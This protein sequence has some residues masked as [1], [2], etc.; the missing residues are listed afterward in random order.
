MRSAIVEQRISAQQICA[1]LQSH[2]MRRAESGPFAGIK[3]KRPSAWLEPAPGAGGAARM[4]LPP[5][6]RDKIFAWE[7]EIKRVAVTEV[8]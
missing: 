2:T 1:F 6:V 8:S 5:N 4:P 7:Q 3:V